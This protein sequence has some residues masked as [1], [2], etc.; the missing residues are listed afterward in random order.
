LGRETFLCPVRWENGWPVVN[1]NQSIGLKMDVPCLPPAPVTALPVRDTFSGGI[2]HGWNWLRNPQRENYGLSGAGLTLTGTAV[3]LD[4]DQNP[5]WM[6]RRQEQ[7]DMCCTTLVEPLTLAGEGRVGLSVFYDCDHHYD[8]ALAE[9]RLELRLC[10]GDIRHT[11]FETA[12]Q[13]PCELEVRADRMKY[14]F[15][16]GHPGHEKQLAGTAITR[17]VSSE[18]AGLSF[19]GVYVAMFAEGDASAVFPWFDCEQ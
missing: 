17:H 14:Q 12:W 18:A 2:G 11:A 3:T 7:F 4:M 8:L 19:T 13:G 9:G 1:E 16:Y 15:W 6:G 10:V 5:T